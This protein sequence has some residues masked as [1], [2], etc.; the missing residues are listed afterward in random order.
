MK[1]A[2]ESPLDKFNRSINRTDLSPKRSAQKP[3]TIYNEDKF[4]VLALQFRYLLNL[5]QIIEPRM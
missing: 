5:N 2:S 1:R 4:K 3:H